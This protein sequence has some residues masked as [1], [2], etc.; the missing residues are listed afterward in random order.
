MPVSI[1]HSP[2][3]WSVNTVA[4]VL[5]LLRIPCAYRRRV[6]IPLLL[7][8]VCRVFVNIVLMAINLL[9]VRAAPMGRI[10]TGVPPIRLARHFAA[11]NLTE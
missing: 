9:P 1:G 10:L 5:L 7:M 3:L 8:A 6:A 2:K 4:L 11:L